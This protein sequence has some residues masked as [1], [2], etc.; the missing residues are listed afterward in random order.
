MK[1]CCWIKNGLYFFVCLM[2]RKEITYLTY[3]FVCMR[4]VCVRVCVYAC[5]VCAR[6]CVCVLCVC[7][8]VCVRV[9][10]RIY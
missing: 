5:C 3:T 7:V 4:V 10:A 8:Y 2:L 1:V 9:R 6:M